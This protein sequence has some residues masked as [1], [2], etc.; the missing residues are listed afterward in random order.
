MGYNDVFP[1]GSKFVAIRLIRRNTVDED[2]A[3]RWGMNA[4]RTCPNLLAGHVEKITC[5]G[6]ADKKCVWN[7]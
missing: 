2:G 4:R 5:T 1:E 3:I 6:S 7:R